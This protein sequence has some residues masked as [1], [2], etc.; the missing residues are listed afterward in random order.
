MTVLHPTRDQIQLNDLFAAIGHPMRLEVVRTLA[1]VGERRCGLLMPD[2][3][4]STLTHHWRVLREGG[5]IWQRP[6]GRELM[7]SLRREDLEARFPGLLQAILDAAE[8]ADP[9]KRVDER[10]VSD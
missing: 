10:T 6:S 5:L 1:T 7:I 9:G 3:A 8:A 4:K 2:I